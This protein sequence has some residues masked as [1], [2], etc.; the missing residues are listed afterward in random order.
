ME[1]R[2]RFLFW[3]K[4]SVCRKWKLSK[5]LRWTFNG[6][7]ME[8]WEAECRVCRK[9]GE[10]EELIVC[11]YCKQEI[12]SPIYLSKYLGSG[13]YFYYH[14]D[15]GKRGKEKERV[16]PMKRDLISKLTTK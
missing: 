15:C 6:K 9:E 8:Y 2:E 10:S 12:K 7:D 3:E 11:E 5:R 13:A 16:K 1:K 4:C 14:M